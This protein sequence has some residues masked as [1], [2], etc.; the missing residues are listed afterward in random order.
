MILHISRI[1]IRSVPLKKGM[2]SLPPAF[3]A[4]ST[5]RS[6]AG[7][8]GNA[9]GRQWPDGGLMHDIF[10]YISDITAT[11]TIWDALGI[12]LLENRDTRLH[13]LNLS[14]RFSSIR[15]CHDEN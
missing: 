10:F 2:I 13:L 3:T 15:F 11:V 5:I 8:E 12:L 1:W 7:L 9:S 4:R 14:S 6:R